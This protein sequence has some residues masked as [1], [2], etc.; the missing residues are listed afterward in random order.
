[1]VCWRGAT[2]P[3][4]NRA[5]QHNAGCSVVKEWLSFTTFEK[6]F[7]DSYVEGWKL[8]KDILVPGNRVYGPETC[9]FVT[10]ALNSL[11]LDC[12]VAR[13]K[14]PLGVC[15]HKATQKYTATIHTGAGQRH[16]G[17][18][19]APLAAHQAWQLAKSAHIKAA[20]TCNPRVRAALDLRVVKLSDDRANGRI[21]TK[22]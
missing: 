13:G 3:S 17:C 22:L 15:F 1:M 11:L 7:T 10:Q 6:W 4:F 2:A 21:T 12:R 9:V 14:Y 5:V 18:F 19:T 20:E 8:D 16:L